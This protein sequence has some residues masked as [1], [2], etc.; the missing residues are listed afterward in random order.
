M[1]IIVTALAA[2]S[3]SI[4]TT[5]QQEAP[6]TERPIVVQKPQEPKGKPAPFVF[7]AGDVELL[8]LIDRC[9]TYL[10]YNILIDS[11]ELSAASAGRG[12]G[13]RAVRRGGRG[14]RPAPRGAQ[15]V[16]MPEQPAG[17]TV[18]LQ[19]PVVTD[20][21]GCEEL[22]TSMLWSHGLALVPLDEHKAVFEV[23]SM[24]GSRAREIV[25]GA[26]RRSPQQV[27]ARPM[28]RRYVTVV[29]NL[30]HTNAQLANNALRPF[31]A[32]YQSN[33]V[34][35]LQIGNIGNRVGII[36]SGPQFMVAN[37]VQLLQEADVPTPEH[38][39]ELE[40]QVSQLTKQNKSLAKR[41]AALEEKLA[42]LSK[43]VD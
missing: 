36:L 39:D 6:P 17:P 19:L 1:Q 8:E 26:V 20:H 13:A 11:M 40:Q 7:E 41:L 9:G 16:K 10:H 43:R 15:A 3:L 30:K 33:S 38:P 4:A 35:N 21:N 2:L 5:C 12:G 29:Y 18:T 28:L 32:N 27:L 25:A 14:N 34:G 31:F 37:A 24:Q 23:L 22:L 42:K